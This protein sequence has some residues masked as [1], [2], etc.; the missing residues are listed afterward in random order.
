MAMTD[1]TAIE[2]EDVLAGYG[3]LSSISV[4]ATSAATVSCL[5]RKPPTK[6]CKPCRASGF[7][8]WMMTILTILTSFRQ[9]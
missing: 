3:S 9:C 7:V 2:F 4:K 8:F 6:D 5:D 1:T